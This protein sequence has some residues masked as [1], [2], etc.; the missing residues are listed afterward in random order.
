MER[1]SYQKLTK[2]ITLEF[3]VSLD[4][5]SRDSLTDLMNRRAY[6]RQKHARVVWSPKI[7]AFHSL[8]IPH[9]RH[10]MI[11][12]NL[13]VNEKPLRNSKR[14]GIHWAWNQPWS[15]TNPKETNLHILYSWNRRKGGPQSPHHHN[16]Y[17]RR[18]RCW[19]FLAALNH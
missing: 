6:W 10:S 5:N 12:N 18:K 3:P 2:L 14:Y 17:I 1:T 7:L 9:P 19:V 15:P 16:K 11:A 8:H 13:A 4:I